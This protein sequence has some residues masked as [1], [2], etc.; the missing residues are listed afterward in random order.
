[1][2]FGMIKENQSMVKNQNCFIAFIKTDDNY[3]DIAE[4][5]E[6]KFDTLDYELDRPLTKGKIT[7]S[8]WFNER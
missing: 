5:V 8:N 4:F 1:M 7:K 2:S 3:R 6:T